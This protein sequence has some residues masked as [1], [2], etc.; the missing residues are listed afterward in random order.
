[1]NETVYPVYSAQKAFGV[2][3]IEKNL[4]SLRATVK[5]GPVALYRVYCSLVTTVNMLP[6]Q[7]IDWI[8]RKDN[9]K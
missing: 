7:I 1:M 6:L 4:S 2:K 9:K 5:T 8:D 3:I